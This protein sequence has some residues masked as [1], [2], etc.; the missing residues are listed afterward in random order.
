MGLLYRRTVGSMDVHGVQMKHASLN[1]TTLSRHT[2]V[3]VRTL[4]MV[5]ILLPTK[6]F[7]NYVLPGMYDT[8]CPFRN[9]RLLTRTFMTLFC[10]N[11]QG[12]E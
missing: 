10:I 9:E 8:T 2:N 5:I 4:V 1:R 7:G 12:A 11:V 3:N 6:T